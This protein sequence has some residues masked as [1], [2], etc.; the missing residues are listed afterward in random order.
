MYL[1]LGNLGIIGF[2]YLYCSVKNICLRYYHIMRGQNC[3]PYLYVSSSSLFLFGMKAHLAIMSQSKCWIKCNS[4]TSKTNTRQKILWRLKSLIIVFSPPVYNPSSSSSFS[5]G[6]GRQLPITARRQRSPAA[7]KELRTQ[8]QK[9]PIKTSKRAKNAQKIYMVMLTTK[10]KPFCR[11]QISRELVW[12]SFHFTFF[13]W[14]SFLLTIFFILAFI[15][16]PSFQYFIFAALNNKCLFIYFP[17]F[18]LKY[19]QS[20]KEN[21]FKRSIF[22]ILL[23]FDYIC[24]KL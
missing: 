1:Y 17:S 10:D 22:S 21:I 14:L 9:G 8:P 19:F 16:M 23:I 3:S 13:Y 20:S 11:A 5:L 15:T 12:G 6:D 4:K 18:I 7:S 24:T 2:P